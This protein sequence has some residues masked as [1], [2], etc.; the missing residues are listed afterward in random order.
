MNFKKIKRHQDRLSIF[1]NKQ[2]MMLIKV[3]LLKKM[4]LI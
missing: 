3:S 2:E 4:N 1:R